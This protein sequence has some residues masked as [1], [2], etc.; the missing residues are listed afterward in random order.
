MRRVRARPRRRATRVPRVAAGRRRARCR[1]Y[2]TLA[3]T[4]ESHCVAIVLGRGL[5]VEGREHGL[6]VVLGRRQLVEQFL[7]DLAGLG[8]V[9]EADRVAVALQPAELALVRIEI[10]HPQLGGVGMRRV[11][12]D[13]LDVDAGDDARLRHDDVHRRVALEAVAVGER[14]VVPAHD[15]RRRALGERGRLA[16]HRHEIARLVEL[17]EEVEAVARRSRR[18]PCRPWRARRHRRPGSPGRRRAGRRRAR[19]HWR[20]AAR[21]GRASPAG[22][23]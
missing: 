19:R 23:A 22:S 3:P 15:D 11:G 10:L 1:R 2:W 21:R 13:R 16:D 8:H 7:R 4:T 17:G 12:A 5:L 6:G 9:V 18:R 14:M 20:I